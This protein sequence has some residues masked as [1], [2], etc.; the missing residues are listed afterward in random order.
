[1]RYIFPG[2]AAALLTAAATALADPRLACWVGGA[3]VAEL[4]A[5]VPGSGGAGFL[6]AQAYFACP[7]SRVD[8][9]DWVNA[10]WE[11]LRRS[12][13]ELES[14]RCPANLEKL[15]R[16]QA[17]DV[18]HYLWE[19]LVVASSENLDR[20]ASRLASRMSAIGTILLGSAVGVPT[21]VFVSVRAFISGHGSCLGLVIGV[22]LF[23]A[24]FW[25]LGRAHIRVSQTIR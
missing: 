7:W 14:F 3:S 13:R 22:L 18:V 21:W 23:A 6:L 12:A 2:V 20:A 16:Q 17:W 5:A 25:L 8:Y 19:E 11:R 10:N 9:S 24:T 4:L 15:R 1:M